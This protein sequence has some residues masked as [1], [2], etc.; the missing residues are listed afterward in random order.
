MPRLFDRAQ[1][2]LIEA[3]CSGQSLME[4]AGHAAA[5]LAAELAPDGLPILVLAGLG[6]NGGDALVAARILKQS[7]HP[8]DLVMLGAPEKL[9]KDATHAYQ[10]WLDIGGETLTAIP[11]HKRYG[12][13]IDG[14]FG[15]GL[16][17]PPTQP[18]IDLIDRIN[19]M[20]AIKLSV[21]IPSGLCAS[22]GSIFGVAVRADHTITYIGHK[23][24]LYTLYGPDYCGHIHFADLGVDTEAALFDVDTQSGW[25]VDSQPAQL[26]PRKKNSHKGSYGSV[27]I[28]GGEISMTGAA[29]LTARAALLCGSG[30]VYAGLLSKL[31]LDMNQ[32]ELM[33]LSVD[34]LQVRSDLDVK[35]IGPGLGQSDAAL[36][37][38]HESL[39]QTTPLLIDADALH[40]LAKHPHEKEVLTQRKHPT[41][42]TPHPGEAA[43]LLSSSSDIVQQDR[44]AAALKIASDYRAIT[45]LKG[46]GSVIAT[47]E[48]YWFIN[49]SGNPGLASA[50]MGDILCGIIAA[51]IA[52]GLD[53]LEATLLGV[54]L[55]GAAADSLVA[56]GVGP[57]G[58]T[59]SE[60]MLK[61]RHLLNQKPTS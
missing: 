23:P 2:R 32:P 34:A 54:Y 21:D 56:D 17:R 8:I 45:V 44:I 55:H 29:L 19:E 50:G 10:N 37:A 35:V 6:N 26:P 41:I 38:L 24:G 1:I 31:L 59:A 7:W 58:L 3:A 5:I 16:Q 60:I 48:G 27:G 53:A 57:V 39:I 51:F 52:Q 25:L 12:L 9:P 36:T 40:L 18:F 61:V 14:L 43:V 47:P 20:Q 22:T 4:K 49:T 33:L 42:L 46:C 13:V 28:I 15:I 11:D 30:K